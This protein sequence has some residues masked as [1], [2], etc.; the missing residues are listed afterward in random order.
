[1]HSFASFVLGILVAI[2]IFII[3]YALICYY[4]KTKIAV[5]TENEDSEDR[6]E[7]LESQR[8]SRNSVADVDA[9]ENEFAN[10]IDDTKIRFQKFYK[11]CFPQQSE[12]FETVETHET[13][14][15][16]ETQKV[17][18]TLHN[19]RKSALFLRFQFSHQNPKYENENSL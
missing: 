2:E 1:M 13:I 17:E 10:F 6:L 15:L 4:H 3:I 7:V 9:N 11:I 8:E 16:T 14:E 19:V 12:T 5:N 18:E